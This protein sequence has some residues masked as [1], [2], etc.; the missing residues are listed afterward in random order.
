[1]HESTSGVPFVTFFARGGVNFSWPLEWLAHPVLSLDLQYSSSLFIHSYCIRRRHSK[2]NYSS[3]TLPVPSP[4]AAALDCDGGSPSRPTSDYNPDA[5]TVVTEVPL[6]FVAE[7][8]TIASP[9]CRSRVFVRTPP[10]AKALAC[11]ILNTSQ[12]S[13]RTALFHT[14]ARSKQ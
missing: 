1:V 10:E 13:H 5:V 12:C 9:K 2:E 14:R 7:E 11:V 6:R 3:A 4:V 8:K